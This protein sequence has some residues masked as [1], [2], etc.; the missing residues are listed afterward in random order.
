MARWV[1]MAFAKLGN[2]TLNPWTHTVKE[3]SV[4]V[5]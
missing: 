3:E 4:V 1:N 5:L 2:V